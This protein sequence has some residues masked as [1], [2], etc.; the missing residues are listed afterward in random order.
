MICRFKFLTMLCHMLKCKKCHILFQPTDSLEKWRLTV[1]LWHKATLNTLNKKDISMLSSTLVNFLVNLSFS[2]Q[3]NYK[4]YKSRWVWV[5]IMWLKW[6]SN[7]INIKKSFSWLTSAPTNTKQTNAQ[8]F[9]HFVDAL[10]CWLWSLKLNFVSHDMWCWWQV[11]IRTCYCKLSLSDLKNYWI[12][13]F[14]Y[15]ENTGFTDASIV[16]TQW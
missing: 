15:F 14:K 11:S 16:T 1:R 10:F 12:F 5:Q 9:G 7:L 8:L 6:K 2:L 3:Y 4:L 13:N